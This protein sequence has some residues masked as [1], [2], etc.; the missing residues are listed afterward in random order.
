MLHEFGRNPFACTN[1]ASTASA[2]SLK[3]SGLHAHN[4][5]GGGGRSTPK[6]YLQGSNGNVALLQLLLLRLPCCHP[7]GIC[8]CRCS[9]QLQLV[10][11]CCHPVGISCCSCVCHCP[12]S[13]TDN[14][15]HTGKSS[16]TARE[17]GWLLSAVQPL[18]LKEA[19]KLIRSG[20]YGGGGWL[21]EPSCGGGE[22][23]E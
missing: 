22:T 9:L 12:L 1:L 21:A 18:L 15:K 14:G 13:T 6:S 16:V 3:I 11:L 2:N 23:S 7:E 19:K 20:P 4:R 17:N 5:G 10:C 8:C